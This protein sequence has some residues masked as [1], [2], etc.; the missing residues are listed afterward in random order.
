[1]AMPSP[2]RKEP[3][4]ECGLLCHLYG[5]DEKP[6]LLAQ[7]ARLLGKKSMYSHFR[8][9]ILHCSQI[10]FMS[11]CSDIYSCSKYTNVSQIM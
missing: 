1:M 3:H 9:S 4:A 10:S 7:P 8:I 5:N 11:E 6:Q 2:D